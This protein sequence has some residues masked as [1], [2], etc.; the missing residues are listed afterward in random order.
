MPDWLLTNLQKINEDSL[1]HAFL[2]TGKKG[3][4]KEL[5]INHLGSLLLCNAKGLK[6]CKDCFSCN[7]ESFNNHPDCYELTVEDGKK[8]I[9]IDQIHQLR[10]K[11]YESA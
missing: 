2:V 10:E 1:H 8:L 6:A 5:F 7:L 11:L 4:G 3:I 9:G